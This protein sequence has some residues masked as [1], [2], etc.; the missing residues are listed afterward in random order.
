[1]SSG[2]VQ[3]SRFWLVV[4]LS[5]AVIAGILVP[6]SAFAAPVL[7]DSYP[8][9]YQGGAQLDVT[10]WDPTGQAFKPAVSGALDSCQFYL[11][12]NGAATGTLYAKLWAHT[13]VYGTNGLPTGTAL[14]VSGP[15]DVA[16][17]P[18]SFGLVTFEFDNTVPLTAGTPYFITVEY[19]DGADGALTLG[20]D[21]G[22]YMLHPGNATY[23]NAYGWQVG[24]AEVLFYVYVTPPDVDDHRGNG[25]DDEHSNAAAHRNNHSHDEHSNAGGHRNNHSKD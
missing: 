11:Q 18:S 9:T 19:R 3:G 14:A 1:M 6:V 2:N 17:V 23:T 8:E 10:P 16:T 7:A 5:M 13:G 22:A 12:R 21:W 25:S 15:V 24:T 20:L 4:G